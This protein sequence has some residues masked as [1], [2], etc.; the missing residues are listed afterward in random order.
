[1]AQAEKK[2]ET[3][4]RRH[5]EAVVISNKMNKTVVVEMSTLMKHPKYGKYFRKYKKLKAHDEKSECKVGD[6]VEIIESR[7]ISK[8]KRFRVTRI[9]E[10]SRLGDLALADEV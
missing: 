2:I 8:E 7:P 1:M 9:V 6:K 4:Q 10:R 3:G 5:I